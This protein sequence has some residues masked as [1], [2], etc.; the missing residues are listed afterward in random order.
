MP[1]MSEY[2]GNAFG[3]LGRWGVDWVLPGDQLGA[4]G[5]LQ[6]VGRGLLGLATQVGGALAPVPGAGLV[7]RQ[8]GI[9]IGNNGNPFDG[10]G[11][12]SRLANLWRAA[13]ALFSR[14][15]NGQ[16][17]APNLRMPQT[18]LPG[19]N[20][21][22]QAVNNTVNNA[23]AVRPVDNS[24]LVNAFQAYR[25]ANPYG[26]SNGIGG[27]LTGGN[28]GM[29]SN[30][31][32]GTNWQGNAQQQNEQRAQQNMATREARA[33]QQVQNRIN[34]SGISRGDGAMHSPHGSG[35]G[36]AG[37]SPWWSSAHQQT[38]TRIKRG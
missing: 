24:G 28:T 26:F 12:D 1:G 15:S 4:N 21:Q 29:G 5:Q 14:G 2:A 34:N 27:G 9:N 17:Q 23:H 37:H 6:N 35:A 32:W 3:R 20:W 25:N 19:N 11:N 18:S 10:T 30:V 13:R 22:G 8:A 38:G 33:M 16:L 31:N 36:G 7:A